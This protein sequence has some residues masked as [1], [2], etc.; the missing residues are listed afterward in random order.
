MTQTEKR[1]RKAA[2]AEG[3]M[4]I[5]AGARVAHV[6]LAIESGRAVVVDL[7]D[8]PEDSRAALI[9]EIKALVGEGSV[10]RPRPNAQPKSEASSEQA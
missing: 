10:P 6:R 3:G 7:S 9:A 8:V 5:S 2:E 4:S 1:F